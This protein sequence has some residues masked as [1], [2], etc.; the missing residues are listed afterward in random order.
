VWSG[1]EDHLGSEQV[2]RVIYGAIIGMALIVV[3]EQHP[4]S[5]GV[6]AGTLIATGLAVALA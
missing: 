1:L 2:S 4:P 6:I 3:L 5:P